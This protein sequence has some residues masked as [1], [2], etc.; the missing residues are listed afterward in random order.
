MHMGEGG[1]IIAP[2]WK[3]FIMKLWT[4]VVET[5]SEQKNAPP[6]VSVHSEHFCATWGPS[7]W[8]PCLWAAGL[9]KQRKLYGEQWNVLSQHVIYNKKLWTWVAKINLGYYRLPIKNFNSDHHMRKLSS[10]LI[11]HLL[12]VVVVVV[13]ICGTGYYLGLWHAI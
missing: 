8:M 11:I 12:V 7:R 5:H 6:D 2:N 10:C 4:A 1:A 9:I 13:L 3:K